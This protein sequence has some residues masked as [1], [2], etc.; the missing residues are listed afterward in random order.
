MNSFECPILALE[1]PHIHPALAAMG[2]VVTRAGQDAELRET[3]TIKHVS[4]LRREALRDMCPRRSLDI[5]HS[6]TST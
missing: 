4:R 5:K 3:R 2:Y 1:A 6:W